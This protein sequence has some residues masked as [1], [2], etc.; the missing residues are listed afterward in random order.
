[1]HELE[2][3]GFTRDLKFFPCLFSLLVGAL[4]F[5]SAQ[6]AALT[7]TWSVLLAVGVLLAVSPVVAA[8]PFLFR[9]DHVDHV[10]G[11]ALSSPLWHAN[12]VLAS[13]MCFFPGLV[14][15]NAAGRVCKSMTHEV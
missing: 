12:G 3:A 1:M 10:V 6:M 2:V 14:I 9:T 11:S 7:S 8:A 4:Q 5:D 15:A 13:V